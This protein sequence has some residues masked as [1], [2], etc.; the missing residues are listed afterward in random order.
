MNADRL[1]ITLSSIQ[2][3]V[4]LLL[5]VLASSSVKQTRFW[6]VSQLLFRPWRAAVELSI[7]NVTF[8]LLLPLPL[9]GKAMSGG[10]RRNG[11]YSWQKAH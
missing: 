3:T 11:S 1:E 6:S 2:D 7:I 10:R 8:L 4:L 5:M 9:A